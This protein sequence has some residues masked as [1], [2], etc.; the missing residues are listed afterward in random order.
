MIIALSLFRIIIRDDKSLF[1]ELLRNHLKP[2][3]VVK[4]LF[5]ELTRLE[6]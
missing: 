2:K 5:A 6:V 3:Q 4:E 1:L